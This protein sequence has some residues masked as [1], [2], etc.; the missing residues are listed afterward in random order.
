MYV[1]N[2]WLGPA[3]DPGFDFSFCRVPEIQGHH[4]G[5]VVGWLGLLVDAPSITSWHDHGYP[6]RPLHGYPF[7]G[8]RMWNCSGDYRQSVA[9][10]VRKDGN[11]TPGA[12]GGPWVVQNRDGN[13][14]ANGTHSM[15]FNDPPTENS[16]PLFGGVVM[17]LFRTAFG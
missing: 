6:M 12:S 14:Y 1:R 8:Q 15:W 9:L 7:D 5:D 11:F 16:S 2:E 10:T 3:V 13:F 4:I 17:D